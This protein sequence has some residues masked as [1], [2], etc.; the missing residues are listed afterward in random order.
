MQTWFACLHFYFQNNWFHRKPIGV[1]SGALLPPS[2]FSGT[3][4]NICVEEINHASDQRLAAQVVFTN[5]DLIRTGRR[6]MWTAGPRWRDGASWEFLRKVWT[7]FYRTGSYDCRLMA[8]QQTT[9]WSA[10]MSMW[11]RRLCTF[12]D[13][14][15]ALLKLS[16]L[17]ADSPLPCILT[18]HSRRCRWR[19]CIQPLCM[20]QVVIWDIQLSRDAETDA[21]V[22]TL[23]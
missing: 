15:F 23:V 22:C 2:V 10:L 13:H 3:C 19:R 8:S 4:W 7:V 6:D 1:W 20:N 17:F 18:V 12:L 14:L 16:L 11:L 9:Y 21:M 5:S